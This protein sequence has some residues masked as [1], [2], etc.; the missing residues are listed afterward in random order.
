MSP[1][2]VFWAIRGS[3]LIGDLWLSVACALLVVVP[4]AVLGLRIRVARRQSD[5]REFTCGRSEDHRG[6]VLVYLFT[7][8]L[9]LF[10]MPLETPRDIAAAIVALGFIVVV[11]WHL[12]LHYMNILFVLRGF[13]VFTLFPPQG[14][15]P[16]DGAQTYV[17]ITRRLA[18]AEG[19]RI[20][21]YRISNSVYLE[22]D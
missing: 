14:G 11:F 12:N 13:R 16:L 6:D 3:K 21:A 5:K 10:V 20:T 18:V 2:F 1:L 15:S 7:M 4:T 22:A 8:L 9:P 19:E 17:L